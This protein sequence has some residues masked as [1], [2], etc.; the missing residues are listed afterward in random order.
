VSGSGS[1]QGSGSAHT[2]GPY[3]YGDAFAPGQWTMRTV[4]SVYAAGAVIAHV[5]CAWGN[6]EANAALIA[7]APDLLEA[8]RAML[9]V[10][11]HGEC[12]AMHP[13]TAERMARDALAKAVQS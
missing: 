10:H 12:E 5:N 11:D 2:P 8:L 3:S 9:T 4:R 6:G 13:D 1:G 7:A